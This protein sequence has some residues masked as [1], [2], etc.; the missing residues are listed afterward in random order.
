[1]NVNSSQ[2]STCGRIHWPVEFKEAGELL[3]KA[4]RFAELQHF[5][6]WDFAV[7]LRELR[8]IGLSRCELRYLVAQ[9]FL[10]HAEELATTPSGDRRFRSTGRL[11]FADRTCFVLTDLGRVAIAEILPMRQRK[12]QIG[13]EQVTNQNTCLTDG[14]SQEWL[15]S[16]KNA[17]KPLWDAGQRRL[18]FGDLLVKQYRTHALNQHLVL[19]AFQEENW[20]E[21]IDDPLPPVEQIEP[22]RRLHDTIAGLNRNQINQV[23]HFFGAGSGRSVGWFA[24]QRP[25]PLRMAALGHCD[26]S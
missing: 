19:A 23:V 14:G 18:I 20:R 15:A 24:K 16:P 13:Q 10:E 21:R 17:I 4:L 11:T 25:E 2:N 1:M 5:S 8:E 22:K 12:D 26:D 7:E 6:P 3:A 9:G